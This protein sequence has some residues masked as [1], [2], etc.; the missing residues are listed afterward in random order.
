MVAASHEERFYAI[1][2]KDEQYEL[3][4]PSQEAT[5]ASLAY[6]VVQGAVFEMHS[7]GRMGAYFS[8]TDNRDEQG[9]RIYGVV[10][11]L[12]HPMPEVNLRV[13]VYGHWA[14][15][16]WPEVFAGARPCREVR[17]PFRGPR[18]GGCT[19]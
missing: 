12:D 13:G 8:C 18:G 17:R 1:R 5:A 3:V 9:F 7:H 6:S 19:T 16:S 14:P 2:W 10:G 4:Q 15:V 11:K